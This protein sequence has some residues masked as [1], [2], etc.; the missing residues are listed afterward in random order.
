[1]GFREIEATKMSGN[2]FEE[3]GNGWMLVSA[4][5]K[6]G[7]INTMTASWGGMGVLWGKDVFFCFVRPGRYTHEFTEESD[8]ISLSFFSDAYKEALKVCGSKSGR[9]CDKIRLAGLTAF[10][11]ENGV[12]FREADRIIYGRKLYAGQIDPKNFVSDEIEKWYDHDYHTVYV[13]EIEK[14]VEKE[15]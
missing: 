10:S 13:C 1:M 3:I 5:K 14:I 12:G 9:D 7:K 4:E 8:R 2:V 15:Q 6:D 11:D